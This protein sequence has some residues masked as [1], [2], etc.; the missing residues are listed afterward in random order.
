VAQTG[1]SE[2]IEQEVHIRARP[3]TV[4]AFFTDPAK[5]I[6]WKGIEATLDPRPGGLY[7]VNIN[8]RDIAAGEYR[9]VVPFSRIVFTW[10]WEA[11]DSPLPPGSSIVEI[12][13]EAEGDGTIV[14]LRHAGLPTELRGL[15]AD[16]WQHYLERLTGAAE[17]R[18][19]G[20]DPW[21]N[22]PG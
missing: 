22:A 4:F 1:Q 5:M 6:L 12:S 10:G 11:A 20:P 3:E 13:L 16:G 19:M 9:E 17:G 14:R 8:G 7:R 18:P 2:A 21:T 15:H